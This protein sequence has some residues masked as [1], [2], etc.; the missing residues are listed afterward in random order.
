MKTHAVKVC[1]AANVIILFSCFNMYAQ[2]FNAVYS[3]DANGN[4][5][6][7]TII[8][9][10]TTLKSMQ[11][12]ST[13]KMDSIQ[14]TLK[15]ATIDSL[16]NTRIS[17]YPNPTHGSLQ[18]KIDGLTIDELSNTNNAI[19]VWN[20]Q[21]K[22]IFFIEPIQND[23]SLDLLAVPDGIYIISIHINGNIKQYKIIKN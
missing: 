10:T 2:A 21:G 15:P 22:E 4:R 18:V 13:T 7:A 17:I 16:S 1:I 9:L 11:M 12:D 3:A 20:L 19:S 6:T 8:Y 5:L 14:T 23:N